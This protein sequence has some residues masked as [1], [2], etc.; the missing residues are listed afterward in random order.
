MSWRLLVGTCLS[1]VLRVISTLASAN[2]QYYIQ[3]LGS[4]I[5]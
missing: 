5:T 4:C 3:L 1:L 2:D